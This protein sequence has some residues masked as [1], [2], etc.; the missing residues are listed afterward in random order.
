MMYAYFHAVIEALDPRY[1]L[2]YFA[3]EDWPNEWIDDVKDITRKVYDED[4]PSTVTTD[5]PASPRKPP[6][7]SGDWPSLLRK[8]VVKVAR[9]ERDELANFWSSP[10]ELL[11]ADPLK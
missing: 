4:Y 1:K 11:S 3:D 7:P 6:P 2:R 5:L 9:R 10:C 8:A